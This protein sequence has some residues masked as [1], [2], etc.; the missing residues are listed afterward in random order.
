MA[1]MSAAKKKQ[2]SQNQLRLLML[3]QKLQSQKVKKKIDSP[4]AKYPFNH[5]TPGEVV[6]LRFT[7]STLSGSFI[8]TTFFLFLFENCCLIVFGWQT[9][10]SPSCAFCTNLNVPDACCPSS[11]RTNCV[12]ILL[13]EATKKLSL[14][15][16]NRQESKTPD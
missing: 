3:Q 5:L 9:K 8:I 12:F 7:Y 1:S 16:V 6:L 13:S 2:V 14:N 15:V 11:I 10:C 4:L